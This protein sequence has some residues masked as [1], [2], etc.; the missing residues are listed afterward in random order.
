MSLKSFFFIFIISCILLEIMLRWYVSASKFAS[1]KGDSGNTDLIVNYSTDQNIGYKT[2]PNLNVSY[3]SKN[4]QSNSDGYRSQEFKNQ[5]NNRIK[6]MAIGD[7]VM[8]GWGIDVKEHFLSFLDA[9][10]YSW[11]NLG[12][13]GYD[14]AQEYFVMRKYF[15]KINP[16]CI[17]HLFVGNDI[18]E[19]TQYNRVLPINSNSYLL[20]GL[21]IASLRVFGDDQHY[22]FEK[23][24]VFKEKNYS[25]EK[26]LKLMSEFAKNK[27]LPFISIL[28]SRYQMKELTHEEVIKIL[29][30][31]GSTVI[32]MFDLMRNVSGE[33]RFYKSAL[34]LNDVHNK[35]YHIDRVDIDYHPNALWHVDAS[36]EILPIIQEQC[37]KK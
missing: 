30:S 19:N 26:Y 18:F 3:L 15:S 6:I 27:E 32:D 10:K 34:A 13:F 33:D 16:D 7:S 25:A 22:S 36:K 12:I 21:Q 9:E 37:L 17:V 29:E 20:N 28:D 4:F 14:S 23:I 5:K 31:N 1:Y 2:K 24:Q 11:F 8:M 35:K